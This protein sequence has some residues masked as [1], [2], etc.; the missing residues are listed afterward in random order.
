MRGSNTR[1]GYKPFRHALFTAYPLK[2]ILNYLESPVLKYN[3]FLQC[4]SKYIQIRAKTPV[5]RSITGALFHFCRQNTP[6][7]FENGLDFQVRLYSIFTF[8]QKNYK[9]DVILGTPGQRDIIKLF[10]HDDTRRIPPV[11]ERILK[12]A[13]FL[14]RCVQILFVWYFLSYTSFTKLSPGTWPL[15][16][17]IRQWKTCLSATIS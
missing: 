4:A 14:L 16:A 15:S 10:P 11:Y 7:I 12:S 13:Y 2:I 3:S 8:Y 6:V 9:P 1:C 5:W 17:Y